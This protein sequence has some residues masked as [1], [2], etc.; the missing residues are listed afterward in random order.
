MM[1]A[2]QAMPEG[3]PIV[4]RTGKRDNEFVWITVSDKVPA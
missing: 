2:A 4:V 1:N 3:G